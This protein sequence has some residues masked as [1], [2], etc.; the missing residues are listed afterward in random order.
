L[1]GSAQTSDTAGE[2][3]SSDPP[4]AAHLP[5][6][7]MASHTLNRSL[8]S[9]GKAFG[10]VPHRRPYIGICNT[11]TNQYLSLPNSTILTQTMQGFII[12]SQE[13]WII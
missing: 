5:P 3:T 11:P 13:W 9:L 1:E 7:G 8:R 6:K 10:R 12:S 2:P 4:S